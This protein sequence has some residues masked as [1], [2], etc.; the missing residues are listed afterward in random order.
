MQATIGNR[1]TC[2]ALHAVPA[3]SGSASV[4]RWPIAEPGGRASHLPRG[5]VGFT[6]AIPRKSFPA[7]RDLFAVG[8]RVQRDPKKRTPGP[9]KTKTNLFFYP[10][11]EFNG[12]VEDRTDF[13][14]AKMWRLGL[15]GGLEMKPFEKKELERMMANRG[16]PTTGDSVKANPLDQDRATFVTTGGVATEV[17]KP[18]GVVAAGAAGGI[19]TGYGYTGGPGGGSAAGG[20][21]GG[22]IVGGALLADAAMGLAGAKGA[23]DKAKTAGDQGGMHQATAHAKSAGWGVAGGSISVAETGVK[24]GTAFGSAAGGLVAATGGLGIAGGA[25]TVAAGLWKIGKSGYKLHKLGKVEP[26]TKPGKTWK[27]YISGREKRKIGVNALKVAAGALG[28]AAGAL[29]LVS[30][31]VGWAVGIAAM[32]TGGAI[33]GFKLF[34]KIKKA[35]KKS[36]AKDKLQQSGQM[37]ELA[38][39]VPGAEPGSEKEKVARQKQV[40]ELADK[41]AAESSQSATH[42]AAMRAALRSG[43]HEKGDKGVALRDERHP[44]D[45]DFSKTMAWVK[46][47]K[48]GAA[49]SF[50]MKDLEAF[51]AASLLAT[52][53]VSPEEALSESG[54]DL[55]AR[56]MSVSTAS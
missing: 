28:I 25:L 34:Q 11:C 52:L 43:D 7:G 44:G 12:P 50:T 56:K 9:S 26:T 48:Q 14:L 21:I 5:P 46:A 51:D 32:V 29:F 53:N 22:E 35:W 17:G 2:S 49:Y 37:D 47:A 45:A 39:P 1:A 18:L 31:P 54:Q 33:A 38:Q 10:G 19:A 24:I 3:G 4:Q 15:T 55:M 30:N 16:L 13:E 20:S 41:V 23:Y 6:E 27:D 36:K 8:S 42:A 40:K